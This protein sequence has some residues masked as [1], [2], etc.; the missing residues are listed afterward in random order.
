MWTD[1]DGYGVYCGDCLMG[2]RDV[3]AGSVAA[4]ITD[5]PYG[6]TDCAWDVVI[7]FAALWPA[8]ARVLRPDG[9]FVTTA[10]QP[11]ASALVMSNLAWFRHEWIWDKGGA[12]N[13]MNL[14]HAPAKI[15]EG[16]Y[17]FAA[18]GQFT[19]NPIRVW[20]SASSL[21]RDPVGTTR[22]TRGRAATTEGVYGTIEPRPVLRSADGKKHPVSILDYSRI[23][24]GVFG[25]V[26]HPTKKPVGLYEY[27][28]R[29]YTNP[30]DTVLDMCCGSGTTL[31]AAVQTGRRALGMEQKPEFVATTLRRVMAAAQR[32]RLLYDG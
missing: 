17:V 19:F 26:V 16:V 4:V 5:L 28:I 25:Q 22:V 9:V 1:V 30:G 11:F 29:V 32:P 20:R 12:A 18:T 7:P 14:T 13:F 23:E 15:H 27:L 6:S 31:V 3:P 21:A 2:L 8:V 10:A 24:K